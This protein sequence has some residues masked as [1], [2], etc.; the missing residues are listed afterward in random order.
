[1]KDEDI[2]SIASALDQPDCK[3]QDLSLSINLLT[4]TACKHLAC[5]MTNNQSLKTLNLSYNNLNG[6]HFQDLMVALSRPTCKIQ[7][8]LLYHTHL[9]HEDAK[10]LELLSSNPSLTLLSISYNNI[11][12]AGS[13][14]IITLI[15]NSSSLTNV[16]LSVNG[17]SQEVKKSFQGLKNKADLNVK[18][19][20]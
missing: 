7:T 18:V 9:T 6:P 2:P 16:R 3:I 14:H 4:H 12:D 11:S 13:K 5:K 19:S 15:E 10:F 20:V 1:M 8:L 17:F